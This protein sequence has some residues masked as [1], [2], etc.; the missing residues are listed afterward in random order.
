MARVRVR[1]TDETH[2]LVR[3]P[4]QSYSWL[5]ACVRWRASDN[6]D[7]ERCEDNAA[8]ILRRAL[9][10]RVREGRVDAWAA[11]NRPP[12]LSRG[13]GAQVKNARSRP[14]F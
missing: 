1:D 7:H 2:G 14:T 11:R 4:R 13:C 8:F 10:L 9:Q 12:T 6:S 5:R 3:A